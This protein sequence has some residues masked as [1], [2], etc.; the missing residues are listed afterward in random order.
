MKN[1][2][3]RLYRY[4]FGTHTHNVIWVKNPH[5]AWRDSCVPRRALI[6]LINTWGENS[7]SSRHG[8]TLNIILPRAVR[9]QKSAYIPITFARIVHT[10]HVTRTIQFRVNGS[11][12]CLT[13]PDADG[14][15]HSPEG[16][17]GYVQ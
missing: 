2:E 9:T 8:E 13:P 14:G 5:I 4:F 15:V 11:K 10:D 6:T 7:P 16:K 1:V 17:V 12:D 3:I